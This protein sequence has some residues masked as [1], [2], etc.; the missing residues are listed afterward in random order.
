VKKK[1]VSSKELSNFLKVAT[2]VATE[3]GEILKRNFGK[4][5]KVELKGE[6]DLITDIDRRSQEFIVGRLGKAFPDHSI[7]AEEAVFEKKRSPYLWIIDPL[8]GTTNYA[9]GFPV[10]CVSIALQFKKKT[11]AGV[12]H[13]P[14][15]GETF[16]AGAGV[17]ARLNGKR[18]VVSKT[19]LLTNSL[20]ATG[21]PY[22]LRKHSREYLKV[23]CDMATRTRAVRRAGSAALDLAYLAC[24]RFDGF[25]EKKLKPWDI[26]AGTLM[27]VEA[28]GKLTNYN[29]KRFD[30]MKGEVAASNAK[31]HKE[32]LAVLRISRRMWRP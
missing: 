2:S 11:I 8:D 25:W 32:L 28:G 27:V 13:N 1:T 30:V 14:L 3:A 4:T 19:R 21:F 17:G 31:I 10:F 15:L 29:G 26:A 5:Q 23:F 22:D 6:I 16:T 9:H 24:G 12:V 7:M 18:I 20:L